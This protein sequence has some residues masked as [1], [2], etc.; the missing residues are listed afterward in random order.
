MLTTRS[1]G[2]LPSYRHSHY[3]KSWLFSVVPTL[4]LREVVAIFHRTDT[5]TTRSRGYL[6]SYRHSHYACRLYNACW[7]TQPASR[8]RP[9]YTFVLPANSLVTATTTSP[10]PRV[11]R[12]WVLWAICNS[13]VTRHLT[14]PTT[15]IL[16]L[17]QA[18]PPLSIV[19]CF[20]QWLLY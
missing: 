8:C 18:N 7:V 16:V 4:S 11:T 17:Q 3:E 12:R 19:M 14:V 10:G 20:I 5:L 15:E 13:K 9:E 1:R 6:P 2:Y